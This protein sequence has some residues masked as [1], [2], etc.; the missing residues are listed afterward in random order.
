MAKKKKTKTKTKK[1]AA[2]KPLDPLRQTVPKIT[3]HPTAGPKITE[4]EEKLDE[5][6]AG[7]KPKR[8]PGRPRKD[9]PGPI[10]PEG[11]GVDIVSG[12]VKLPF[13]L[14]AIKEKVEEL[15]LTDAEANQIAEPF[16]KLLDY[17]LPQIPEI[18][19]AWIALTVNGFWIMR[20]R[21]LLI[22]AIKES[23]EQISSGAQ[24]ADGKDVGQGGPRPPASP[25]GQGGKFPQQTETVKV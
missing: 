23:N 1:A 25:A 21:L 7:D 16:K 20:T 18:A 24:T 12:V 14:W 8:G 10:E 6:L 19:Y 5:Q 15:V 11:V 9:Q 2:K 17:Y 22:A 13:E 4:F 3:P